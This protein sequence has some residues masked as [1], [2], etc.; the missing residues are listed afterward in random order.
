[1]NNEVMT[2][3]QAEKRIKKLKELI[4]K[5]RYSYH[6]LDKSLVS[7][8][9]NDSLKH[10]LQ[11]LEE[12]FPELVTADSPTQ[13]VGGKPLP[14]FGKVRHDTPMLSLTDCFSFEELTEWEMRL[15]RL[16]GQI[17]QM[18]G[19]YCELKMDGLAVSLVYEHGVF[20]RGAT[21]GDGL[22]GEEVTENLRTVEAIPLR[23][24]K[25]NKGRQ[26][27]TKERVE[28]RGEV[29][30]RKNVFEKLNAQYKKEGKSLL[31]NPRNAAAGSIRQLDPK[32]TASRKLSFFAYDLVTDLG[33]KSHE[34]THQFLKAMGFPV[35]PHSRLARNLQ[36]VEDFHKKRETDRSDKKGLPYG[37][38]GV[39]VVLNDVAT[40]QR[41]GVVGKAPRGMIAYKFS[42]E[43]ATTKLIAIDVQVGRQGTLTPVAKLEPVLLAGSMVSR[44]TLHN[45]DEIDRKDVRIGDTVVVRKAGDVIPEVVSAVKE[46]RSGKEKKFTMPK[47]CPV[48]G[49]G[50]RRTEIGE[51]KTEN[52]GRKMEGVAYVCSNPNCGEIERR[53]LAHFVSKGAFDIVGLGPKI[54]QKLTAHGILKK[55]GDIFTLTPEDLRDVEGFAELSAHKL[56]DSIASKK[57]IELGRLIYALG[58]RHVGEQNAY[59]LANYYHNLDRITKASL[60][61]LEKLSE[62]GPVIARSVHDFFR[63]ER[64]KRLLSDLARA[65]IT[66]ERPKHTA[67]KISGKAFVFTGGLA[68]MSRD[69]AKEKVRSLGGIAQETVSQEVDFVVIG[70]DAGSKLEKAKQ[71]GV[72]IIDEQEF[73][74]MIR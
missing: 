3:A 69:I 54:L 45:Q 56:V 6:V 53:R 68:T 73:L 46:L 20:V 35:E 65:G 10:E 24:I 42:P 29:F 39:V 72:K 44:A 48:C 28:V 27:K 7:D 30:M 19:Y 49:S 70:T 18:G 21:R 36:E 43:E 1:M 14:Q 5:H 40:F 32:V 9:V 57:H 16:T 2:K 50:V 11:Q 8:A 4:E 59:A 33:Q 15:M 37:T 23:I 34:E 12:Q 47:R 74:R 67:S 22:V 31:A 13:R 71:L 58:I 38:D 62:V 52:G 55:A 63:Q 64:T 51:Q 25:E 60:K 17:G 41:L 66:I 61:E 26:R